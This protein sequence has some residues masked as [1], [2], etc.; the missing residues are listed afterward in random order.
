M[1][2]KDLLLEIS[3]DK[4]YYFNSNKLLRYIGIS[5]FSLQ[6]ERPSTNLTRIPEPVCEHIQ[7]ER[8][9]RL[10]LLRKEPMRNDVSLCIWSA[11]TNPILVS[12]L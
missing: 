12:F 9:Q 8:L 6:D 2:K 11:P 5:T 4:N 1:E 10:A 3:P 7:K